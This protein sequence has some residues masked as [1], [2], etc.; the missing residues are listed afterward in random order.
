MALALKINRNKKPRSVIGAP[1]A[2]PKPIQKHINIVQRT[3]RNIETYIAE[4]NLPI[5]TI[6]SVS[7]TV[8]D[9]KILEK[10]SV[11]KINSINSNIDPTGS[12]DDPRMGTIENY[13][14]CSTCEKTNDECPGHMGIM[15]LATNFIHPYYR[16]RVIQVLSCICHTC[17]KLLISDNMIKEKGINLLSGSSR[18]K[19]IVD[20]CS[21]LECSNPNCAAKPHFKMEKASK[22]DKRSV[23]YYIIKNKKEE[24][25]FM[26]VDSVK[27][28]LDY[29]SDED[30]KK[31]GF[32]LTHPR[33]F[34][35]DF[36]PV[37]PLNDR[38]Y[39]IVKEVEKNKDHHITYAYKDILNKNIESLQYINENDREEC[40]KKMLMFYGY[41]IKN[42]KGEYT[43]AQND[44]VKSITDLVT[45]KD[46]F[47][48]KH[49][50]GKRCDFCGRTPIGPNEKLNFGYLAMPEKMR[51]LTKPEVVTVYNYDNI[52]E[53]A[54]QGRVK[55]ICPGRG[56]LAG[57]KL[58][59]DIDKHLD[60]ISIGDKIDRTASEGDCFLFNRAPTL[61]RQ[62]MLSFIADFQDK[63]SIGLHLSNTKGFNADFDGDEGNIHFVQT[64]D[65]E[66]EARLIMTTKN[67]VI[68]SGLSLAE[69][70]IVYNSLT[71]A[72]L[73]TRENIPMSEIDFFSGLNYMLE[74]MKSNYIKDNY[75]DKKKRLSEKELYTTYGLCSLLFPDDFWYNENAIVG[76][77]PTNLFISNGIIVRGIMSP[78][79]E[80][81]KN[82][83]IIQSLWKRYDKDTVAD[84]I[85]SSNFLFNW[86][87]F[88][89][90]FSIGIKDILIEPNEKKENFLNKRKELM[91]ELNNELY[92]LPEL[93][94][95][96]DNYEKEKY[97]ENLSNI[98][99]SYSSKIT[100]YFDDLVKED[101]EN[102]SIFV[103][104]KS[105][106]K[107]G[108]SKTYNV[109]A[110]MGQIFTKGKLPDKRITGGK[111]WLTTFSV[112]DNTAISR[113]FS[114]NSY[115]EGLDPDEYFAQAQ[116]GR[117]TQIDTA[118]G[119]GKVGYEQR[120]LRAAQE[121]LI[122]YHDGSVRN[123][124]DL[125]LQFSYGAGF[126][127]SNM[128]R[129][130]SEKGFSTF[131]FINL[132]ELCGVVN[133]LNGFNDF[134]IETGIKNI[135]KEHNEKFN[136]IN[137]EEEEILIDEYNDNDFDNDYDDD[138]DDFEP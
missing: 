33:N 100:K 110:S 16:S 105:G 92:D 62:S 66:V 109:M 12:L 84:F 1:V 58:K 87:I 46:G 86:Y 2:K 19:A 24:E 3:L 103:M 39:N 79:L 10:L 14:L 35:I 89:K 132:K 38:P 26:S 11:C 138:E 120:K 101:V 98:R 23:P 40:Y 53:M 102:N 88:I 15:E 91:E 78:F 72:F 6:D 48:R 108:A 95:T 31:L 68:N 136:F 57:R 122:N 36:L 7:M 69:A 41:L 117:L 56:N 13:Q 115:L 112:E 70:G 55:Y 71:G 52:L 50:M 29:I 44:A 67:C 37:I 22:N 129:D 134:S 124:S 18:L 74:R 76:K 83:G 34:I 111:R 80:A 107:G 118:I 21:S 94:P 51:N 99:S 81:K 63:E 45:Q 123:Q 61:H 125:I 133:N 130:N 65:S 25:Y 42:P 119:T 96:A 128:I 4:Q 113:G 104:S 54:R 27:K 121:D 137:E 93:P 60:K 73:M 49:I 106:A 17:N 32:N 5:G 135:I 114:A 116:D 97:E 75:E 82:N 47:I 77:F 127:T 9:K 85:S 59:F 90:G 126:S 8:F 64:V 20:T 131:S 43:R 30:A 28:K